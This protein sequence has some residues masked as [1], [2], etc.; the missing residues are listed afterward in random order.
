MNLKPLIN[1]KYLRVFTVIGVFGLIIF[2]FFYFSKINLQNFNSSTVRLGDDISEIKDASSVKNPPSYVT[3]IMRY[4]EEV[5][6]LKNIPKN[7]KTPAELKIM[8]W[9]PDWDLA[10]GFTTLKQYNFN[11]VS[12]FWLLP[13]EDGSIKEVLNKVNPEIISYADQNNIEL[14]PT[15][16][17]FD[18]NI[19]STIFNDEARYQKFINEVISRVDK[20]NYDGIDL[21]FEEIKLEDKEIFFKFLK[22]I[23]Q[24][25]HERNKLVSFTVLPQWSNEISYIGHPQTRAVQDYL[26]ISTIVDEFRI[27]TYDY[28]GRNSIKAGPVAPLEWME[29][30][31]QYA[32][33]SGVPREKIVLGIPT[34]LYDWSDREIATQINLSGDEIGLG[35][36]LGLEPGEAYYGSGLQKVVNNY[37]FQSTFNSDWG[38]AIGRY[39]YQGKS[40]I[41]VFPTNES[42]L[43]RKELAAEYGVKG[44]AY[45]R[46]G[47]EGELKL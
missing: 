12:P 21:D 7:P 28:Y 10:D 29:R 46:L 22:E 19:F 47:D 18:G 38:E 9:I 20:Y 2:L 36:L 11:S 3:Q 6:K 32:I 27:M 31:I 34:Y 4:N 16:P 37:N 39:E 15:I 25:V 26:E 45:W 8:G 14:I 35:S 5:E 40:R 1:N 30:V 13:Q 24:K 42:I 41:V 23:T 17:L 43:L 44:I 33:F